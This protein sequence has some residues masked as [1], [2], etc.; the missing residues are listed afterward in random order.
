MRKFS[1]VGKL[2][3]DVLLSIMQEEKPNQKE[4]VRVP[5]YRISKYL[6]PDSC[7]NH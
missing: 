5:K 7:K 3:K 4:Q 2:N 1:D 6:T